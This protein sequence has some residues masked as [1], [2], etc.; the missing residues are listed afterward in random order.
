MN[1]HKHQK[2]VKKQKFI[3]KRLMIFAYL[4]I[5]I[6]FSICLL[7]LWVTLHKKT[8]KK[9]LES[10]KKEVLRYDDTVKKVL[11][12]KKAKEAF[13]IK[14]NAIKNLKKESFVSLRLFKIISANVIS[15]KMWGLPVEIIMGIN[16]KQ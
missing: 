11:Q 9:G 14:N 3:K 4:F 2:S 7:H 8:V 10:A 5:C 6:C 13:N 16:Q 15:E 12:I 1:K